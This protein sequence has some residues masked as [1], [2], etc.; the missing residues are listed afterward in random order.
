VFNPF[1]SS[2]IAAGTSATVSELR[3]AGDP[4]AERK[5]PAPEWKPAGRAGEKQMGAGGGEGAI[6]EAPERGSAWARAERQVGMG[7][8]GGVRAGTQAGKE[9]QA[10]NRRIRISA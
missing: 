9:G 4:C 8:G 5:A 7:R 3:A 2:P 10:S 6:T 1:S